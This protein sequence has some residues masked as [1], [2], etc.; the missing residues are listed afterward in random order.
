MRLIK[1]IIQEFWIQLVISTIWASYKVYLS[2]S[3]EN[4]ILLFITH[5]STALFLTSWMMGQAIRI[6]KQQKIED[7]FSHIK[8]ELSTL[9]GKIEH[10][11]EELIGYSLGG[12]SFAY[13]IPVIRS[14]NEISLELINDSKYP[15]FDITGQWLD[16]DQVPNL[17]GKGPVYKRVPFNLKDLYPGMMKK[18]LTFDISN[19]ESLR[20]NI[21]IFSRNSRSVDQNFIIKREGESIIIAQNISSGDNSKVEIPPNFPG[22]D[23]ENPDNVFK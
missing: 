21:F 11:A 17:G 23:L 3:S 8:T 4:P 1:Q 13:F 14:E 2:I 5:F 9:L 18:A 6:K 16:M 22:Y 15:V 19:K 7:E 20:I 10:Q 12:N